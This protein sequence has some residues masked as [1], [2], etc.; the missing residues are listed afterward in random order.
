MKKNFPSIFNWKIVKWQVQRAF[1][2]IEAL[3]VVAI[4]ALLATLSIMSVKNQVLKGNDAKRKADINRIKIAVEEYEK[5]HNCYPQSVV[6]TGGGTG[7][8]P[9]LNKI[10]C[11]STTNQ[12][13]AYEP[14]CTSGGCCP[15]WYRFYAKLQNTA[16]TEITP[17]IGPGNQ[18]NFYSISY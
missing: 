8:Q 13:Y 7:L 10:P 17:S 14:S 6:C 18:Y 1:T 15:N 4:L 5:D 16:D 12:S 11:D 2:L 9:Y 3:I